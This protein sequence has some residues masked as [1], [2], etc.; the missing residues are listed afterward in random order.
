MVRLVFRPYT[1][2][3]R[4]ICT[5][6]SLRASTRVSSGFAPLRHSSPSFGSRQARSH[7][8]PSQKI[9]VG[10]RCTR[11]KRDPANQLPGA[12]RVSGTRRLARMSDSLVRVSRRAGW[13][14]HGPL[15]RAYACVGARRP[16]VRRRPRSTR[17]HL[18]GRWAPGLE[19]PTRSAAVHTSSPAVDR[20][21]TV[22]HPTEAHRQ[23]PFASLPTISSTL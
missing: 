3:R 17:R 5:S 7:S 23:P 1:Q 21:D 9:W 13:G 10:R 8:N 16:G 2:V 15:P 6:V 18:R 11:Q 4:T 19:S 20:L 12:F 14:T 22:P